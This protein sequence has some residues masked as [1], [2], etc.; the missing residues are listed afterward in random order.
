MGD[1]IKIIDY[2]YGDYNNDD[3]L[4]LII[5][6][7]RDGSYSAPSQTS[8]VIITSFKVSEFENILYSD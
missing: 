8:T 6:L 3:Y 7:N 5:R 2:F 1:W 4:D